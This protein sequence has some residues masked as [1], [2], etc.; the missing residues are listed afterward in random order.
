MAAGTTSPLILINE[1]M[2]N[3]YGSDSEGEWIEIVNRGKDK[4]NLYNWKIDD[5]Q[6]G[7]SA[8]K[9]SEN[10]FLNP[11]EFWLFD[12]ED[13]G[14][15]LN[16]G[17]DKVVIYDDKGEVM[18]EIEYNNPFEGGAYVKNEKGIWQWSEIATPGEDNITK[19][20]SKEINI[21]NFSEQDKIENLLIPNIVDL[22]DV[23]K[24]EKGESIVVEGVVS[25]LPGILGSQI[26]YI[27][28]KNESEIGIQIYSYK[29]DFPD[30][31]IG[32]LVEVLGEISEVNEEKRIKISKISDIKILDNNFSLSPV[33]K[34][35]GDL[36][37]E[38]IGGLVVIEGEIIEKKGANLYVDDGSGEIRV[39][40]KNETGINHS[41]F[42]TGDTIR[43]SGILGA[44]QSG[45]RLLPRSVEDLIK[46]ESADKK[47]LGEAVENEEWNLEQRK[48]NAQWVDYF[49]IV[50]FLG[51]G[52]L[53]FRNKI[54]Q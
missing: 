8:Y 54:F 11:G 7:S 16:N 26:F 32:D 22:K 48:N 40:V 36:S 13:T 28:S 29:K 46:I 45:L 18:D 27:V 20:T 9:I 50:V 31:K 5:N 2:P 15:A 53:I 51:I 39:F 14:I 38:L 43:V 17:Y 12:R 33:D 21:F 25:V 41:D 44:T 23:K 34:T 52:V 24:I 4:V 6:G 47:V 1:I 37:E 3:P 19:Q 49:L 35:C 10:I 42:K 30:F